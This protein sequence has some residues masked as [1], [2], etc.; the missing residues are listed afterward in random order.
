MSIDHQSPERPKRITATARRCIAAVAVLLVVAATA[1]FTA[2]DASATPRAKRLVPQSGQQRL[3][4]PTVDFVKVKPTPEL[5]TVSTQ[6]AFR[7]DG[8]WVYINGGVTSVTL[9]DDTTVALASPSNGPAIASA[10]VAAGV[11]ATYDGFINSDVQQITIHTHIAS[12]NYSNGTTGPVD[13]TSGPIPGVCQVAITET[14]ATFE[15]VGDGDPEVF[16]SSNYLLADTYSL[17]FGAG[18]TITG[19]QGMT[20]AGASAG[21]LEISGTY[22]TGYGDFEFDAGIGQTLA[23]STESADGSSATWA[24]SDFLENDEIYSGFFAL[25]AGPFGIPAFGPTG[26]LPVELD[27][28]YHN[29]MCTNSPLVLSDYQLELTIIQT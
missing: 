20:T 28:S 24:L 17:S 21:D 19:P 1:G 26:E 15:P 7:F 29:P 5:D 27:V 23:P 14:L 4:V 3:I 18:V 8:R 11:S 13:C 25:D 6:C 2:G 16:V 9:V 22:F 10:L 12:V